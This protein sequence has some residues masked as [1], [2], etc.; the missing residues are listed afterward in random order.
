MLSLAS[1]ILLILMLFSLALVIPGKAAD[2]ILFVAPS[3][4]CGSASPC[5]GNVQ[6]A[7]DAARDGEEI[8]VAAGTYTDIH[9]RNGI[10]QVLYISKTVT[11]RGGYTSSNWTSPDPTANPTTLD[12]QSQGRVIYIGRNITPT[13]SGLRITGG[14]ASGLGGAFN[15]H[16]SGGGIYISKASAAIKNCVI[17]SNTAYFGGGIYVNE[18]AAVIHG[19]II[20]NNVSTN[21]GGGIGLEGSTARIYSN[22]IISNTASQGAGAY[23]FWDNSKL[24]YNSISNNGSSYIS[25]GGLYLQG[26]N[27]VVYNNSIKNNLAGSG[28]GLILVNSKANLYN[29]IILS[30]STLANGS[31]FYIVYGAPTLVNN[32]IANNSISDEYSGCAFFISGGASP[33]IIHN[34][35]VSNT[36]SNGAAI[37]IESFDDNYSNAEITN[38]ILISHSLG[39]SVT[40]GNTA[41]L[42]GI[43]WFNTPVTIT[44]AST[45]SVTVQNQWIGDPLFDETDG[46]HLTYNSNAIDRGVKTTILTDIDNQPRFQ[47]PDL[48]ADEFWLPGYPKYAYLPTILR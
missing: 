8:R 15:D 44:Q 13:V 9:A 26:G 33:K 14:N 40:G 32:V 2:V 46:Y 41:T 43:L 48:G 5:F 11:I 16:D 29:N 24:E 34:T 4:N 35:I 37:H 28:G 39:I 47:I 38:T 7:I 31:G 17:Y 23:L 20:S 3:A 42:N 1:G 6:A 27:N 18:S 22:S 45:A 19:N 10:T 36:C 21:F 30:N 12:A 25:G